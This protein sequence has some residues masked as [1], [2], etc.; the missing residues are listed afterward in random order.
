MRFGQFKRLFSILSVLGSLVVMA[1][2]AWAAVTAASPGSSELV[3]NTVDDEPDT[4]PGDGQCQTLARN[5]TLRA[6]L[7]EANALPGPDS[8]AFNISGAGPHTILPKSPLPTITEAVIIDGQSEPDYMQ[9]PVIFLDGSLAGEQASGLTITSG[10]SL[11]RGLA[12]YSFEYSGIYL[13]GGSSNRIENNYLGTTGKLA[14][15]NHIGILVEKSALNIIGDPGAGNLISSNEVGVYLYGLGASENTVAGNLIGT[16]ADGVVALGNEYGVRITFGDGNLVGGNDGGDRNVITG[17][18]TGIYIQGQGA[19]G[20]RIW[21]NYIGLDASGESILGNKETG[22]YILDAPG[23]Q[24]GGPNS[25]G[26]V[27]AGGE[28]GVYVRGPGSKG[29]LLRNNL[30]GTDSNQRLPMQRLSGGVLVA[31]A[32]STVIGGTQVN[33]GN[34][35]VTYQYGIRLRGI[36]VDS[37]A[38]ENNTLDVLSEEPEDE[39]NAEANAVSLLPAAANQNMPTW[40]PEGRRPR[41]AYSL[42]K[43]SA[44]PFFQSGTTFTVNTTGDGSDANVGDGICADSSGNCTLRAAI[45]EANTA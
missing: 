33:Q 42:S 43:V 41:S 6:A 4:Q 40:T 28:L 39:D 2:A 24:V 11:V 37:T 19:S 1:S 44:H 36:A 9:S 3:V 12:I 16:D 22:V 27:I 25:R 45:E 10:D 30:I 29:N 17:N 38:T 32:S 34:H 5:C 26:N 35:I 23:N 21:G 20:N 14:Q 15:G 31:E 18:D 13:L 8:I 7:E